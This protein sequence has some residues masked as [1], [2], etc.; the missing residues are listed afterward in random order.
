M[1]VLTVGEFT[2]GDEIMG[3]PLSLG[4]HKKCLFRL[5]LTLVKIPQ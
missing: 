2:F 4:M 5:L 1:N 3:G